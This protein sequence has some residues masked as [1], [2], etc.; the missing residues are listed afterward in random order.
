MVTVL[1][2]LVFLNLYCKTEKEIDS[3]NDIGYTLIGYK[4]R[5]EIRGRIFH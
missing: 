2:C 1:I 3:I 5:K 4:E